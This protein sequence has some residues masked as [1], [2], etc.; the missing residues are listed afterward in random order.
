M[1]CFV[2]RATGPIQVDAKPDDLAWKPA[3]VAKIDQYSW[4]ELEYYPETEVRFLYDDD[5]LYLLFTCT[6]KYIK[7]THV[8]HQTEVWLDNCVELFT[9]P[10]PDLSEPYFN[11]EFNCLGYILLGV[12][13][14]RIGR[15]PVSVKELEEVHCQ[16]TYS[17]PVD[18]Q[19]EA[20]KT[21]YLEVAIPFALIS[22]HSGAGAPRSG[23]VWRANFN[24]CSESTIV[25]HHATWAPVK[26]KEPDFHRPDFFGEMVF[27]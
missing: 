24:K 7:A 1:K 12:G 25:V 16:A 5:N 6:E 27:E 13:K 18:L 15:I 17:E 8:G 11:F 26:T 19:D 4:Q 22:R 23:T 20:E 2:K 9:S 21:W 14:E 10:S 3:H